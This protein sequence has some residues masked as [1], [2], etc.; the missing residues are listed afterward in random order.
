VIAQEILTPLAEVTADTQSGSDHRSLLM[1]RFWAIA[2]LSKIKNKFDTIYILGSWYGNVALML[3]L[4]NRYI[5]FDRIINDDTNA[6][7]LAAGQARLDKLGL[8]RKIK[9]IHQDA[10]RLSYDQMGTDGLVINLS[11]HN[12]KGSSWCDR[13][14]NGTQVVLQ[15]RNNDPAATNQFETF[16]Q[17]DQAYQLSQTQYQGTLTLRDPDGL[18]QDYMKIGRK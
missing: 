16:E 8:D 3:L 6:K 14:P 1:E 4:L 5:Q 12:I 13:I 11:C 7:S 9:P 18:Y 17:F 2:M 15:T 10:N